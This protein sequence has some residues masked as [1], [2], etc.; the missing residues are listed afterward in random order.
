MGRRGGFLAVKERSGKS[1]I[2]NVYDNQFVN[3]GAVYNQL[4]IEK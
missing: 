1:M 4:T 3:F 2:T